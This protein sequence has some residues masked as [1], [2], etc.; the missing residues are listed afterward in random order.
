MENNQC[1]QNVYVANSTDVDKEVVNNILT[2]LNLFIRRYRTRKQL[3]KLSPEQL[4]DVGLSREQ[5]LEESQKPF[6]K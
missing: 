4:R 6:W 3:E 2:K 1:C 5:V